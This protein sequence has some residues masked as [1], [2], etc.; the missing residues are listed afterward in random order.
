VLARKCERILIP[1][2]NRGRSRLN[3]NWNKVI[4]LDLSHVGLTKYTNQEIWELLE[5]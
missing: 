4:K 1:N 5:D 3:K 2:C